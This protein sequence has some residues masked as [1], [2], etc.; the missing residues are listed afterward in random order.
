MIRIFCVLR[1]LWLDPVE[2]AVLHRT[3][4]FLRM[5]S[6]LSQFQRKKRMTTRT[7]TSATAAGWKKMTIV[8]IIANEMYRIAYH[9][10]R[11]VEALI[12]GTTR[13]LDGRCSPC[14]LSTKRIRAFMLDKA[15]NIR[16]AKLLLHQCDQLRDLQRAAFQA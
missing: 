14:V 11:E 3:L 12:E 6:T 10:V 2:L 7:P 15:P 16:E 4:A 8:A 9:T 13:R 1:R 5:A